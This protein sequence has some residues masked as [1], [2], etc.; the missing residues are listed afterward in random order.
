MKAQTVIVRCFSP[1]SCCVVCDV[2]VLFWDTRKLQ[3]PT[4]KFCMD[5]HKKQDCSNTTGAMYL[6]YDPSIVGTFT[7]YI[8]KKNCT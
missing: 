4:E 8:Y 7:K 1:E 2:E 6:E 3:E 5:E